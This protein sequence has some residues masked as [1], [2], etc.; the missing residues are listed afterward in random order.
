ML[1][2]PGLYVTVAGDVNV[3][4]ETKISPYKFA[5]PN[6]LNM[7]EE[8]NVEVATKVR[9]VELEVLDKVASLYNVNTAFSPIITSLPMIRVEAERMF[10][11]VLL[12]CMLLSDTLRDWG[13]YI[14]GNGRDKEGRKITTSS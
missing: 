12:I 11:I 13:M 14:V 4:E 3:C 8:F 9:E 2:E 1:E 6:Q 10:S 5:Y 7:P